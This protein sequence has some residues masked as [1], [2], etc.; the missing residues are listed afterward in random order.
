[1]RFIVILSMLVSLSSYANSVTLECHNNFEWDSSQQGG[2]FYFIIKNNDSFS[3]WHEPYQQQN[4]EDPARQLSVLEEV[5]SPSHYF[6]LYA[7]R[8]GDNH[9]EFVSLGEVGLLIEK[10]GDWTRSWECR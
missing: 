9:Y 5:D 6:K 2:G 8:K 7:G 4:R 1:M 3:L 10:W